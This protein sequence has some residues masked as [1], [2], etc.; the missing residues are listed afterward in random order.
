[1]MSSWMVWLHLK[2]NDKC[3]YNSQDRRRQRVD[4]HV[5]AEIGV[6]QPH[7]EEHLELVE[8]VR[9]KEGFHL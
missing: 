6:M 8:F 4:S 5:K 3:P 2:S 1:M 9:G 7:A